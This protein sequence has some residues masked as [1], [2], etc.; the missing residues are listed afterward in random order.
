MSFSSFE[1]AVHLIA[2]TAVV[3]LSLPILVFSV[4]CLIGCLYRSR[5]QLDDSESLPTTV[6]LIPAHNEAAGIPATLH[7]LRQDA[8]EAMRIVVVADNCTDDTAF[9]VE[10][11][12]CEVIER[13]D[14]E[15]L[16]KGY[17]LD[18]GLRHIAQ[19]PPQVVIIVDADCTV[20]DGALKALVAA[21]MHT[22]RPVQGRYMQHPPREASAKDVMSAFAFLVKNWTRPLG[23]KA[24]GGPCLLTGSGMAFPWCALESVSLGSGNIVED[25]QLGLDLTVAG[26]PPYF[27]ENAAINAYLPQL[28]AVAMEQRKRWEHG[29][30]R[31]L[32][33][34]LSRLLGEFFKHP[35]LDVL[36]LALDLAVPPLSLLIA[37]W[38]FV[39]FVTC[40]FYM[41]GFL[42]VSI[43]SLNA[44]QCVLLL[45]AVGS[46]WMRF[47][48]GRFPVTALLA[49]PM[50]VLRKLPLY[51]SYLIKPQNVWV[52]TARDNKADSAAASGHGSPT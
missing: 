37:V 3:A 39:T 12:G 23:L 13:F 52:R 30:L 25:M 49:V 29:H 4:E 31:T 50:Y 19:D 42:H 40:L 32:Q 36:A 34:Q 7:S 48:H 45:A 46:S 16:G 41:L 51:L 20:G 27:A 2:G 14:S 33:T 15:R 24:L 21:V 5:K 9:I 6:I 22:N 35:R 28:E 1:I 10:S 47:G 26:H 44:L 11:C 17:A 43:L 8:G 18:Y 38:V